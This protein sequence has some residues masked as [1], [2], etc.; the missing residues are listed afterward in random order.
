MSDITPD[1]TPDIIS[2]TMPDLIHRIAWLDH[3]FETMRASDGYAG[4]VVHWWQ[5]CLQ[6][7]GAGLDWRYEGIISGYLNLYQKTGD[8]HWLEKAERAGDDL[9]AGQYPGGNFRNSSFELNPYSGGRPHEAAADIALLRLAKVTGSERY[10]Q[11]AK[12]NIDCY[13]IQQLWADGVFHDNLD[14]STF[15]PNKAATLSESLLLLAS[16]TDDESYALWYALPTL[17]RILD[18]QISDGPLRGAIYQYS[19]GQHRVEWFF[20]YYAAR[21]I[22]ALIMSFRWSGD[23]RYLNAAHRAADF[24][25]RWR[26]PDGGF[27]QVIYRDGR[28]NRYPQWIAGA[29]DILR[30]LAL[31]TPYGADFDLAPSQAWLLSGQLSS[32]GFRSAHGFASQSSQRTPGFLPDFRDVLPVCGWNDKAFRYLT[33]ALPDQIEHA[34]FTAAVNTVRVDPV[35]IDCTVRGQPVRF[36]ED[37]ERIEL[38]S[39]ELRAVPQGQTL[40]RWHKGAMWADVCVQSLLWK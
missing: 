17:D 24:I 13:F 32:G 4:P 7:T 23:E 2:G 36:Y 8:L 18:H 19:T 28:V 3:W 25:M 27:P 40:Y 12:E 26:S 15:V 37:D 22:P 16:L 1:L 14:H 35:E 34:A 31:L 39:A 10:L 6:Y 20:P 30:A 9:V 11:A 29:A 38:R 21:C 5:N 33:S